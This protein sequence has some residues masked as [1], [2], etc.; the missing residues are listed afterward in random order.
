MTKVTNPSDTQQKLTIQSKSKTGK[1]NIIFFCIFCKSIQTL[2]I[3]MLVFVTLFE[4]KCIFLL[5]P[6]TDSVHGNNE[7][8]SEASTSKQD[9]SFTIKNQ[10]KND[11]DNNE[12][13]VAENEEYLDLIHE[14]NDLETYLAGRIQE[15][16]RPAR[17][18]KAIPDMVNLMGERTDLKKR[19]V[20]EISDEESPKYDFEEDDDIELIGLA[21][22]F[23]NARC[24]LRELN[25]SLF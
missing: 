13:T 9:H 6:V 5:D 20:R 10:K 25:V 18:F 14:P 16:K 2:G 19:E 22:A 24:S 3:H 17:V 4:T 15:L 21:L 1:L 8:V 7:D 11:G 12:W 23:G